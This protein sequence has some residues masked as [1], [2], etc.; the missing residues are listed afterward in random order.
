MKKTIL[1]LVVNTADCGGGDAT[2]PAGPFRGMGMQRDKKFKIGGTNVLPPEWGGAVPAPLI[3][4]EL[5]EMTDKLSE[6]LNKKV[7]PQGLAY[8]R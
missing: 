4:C 1:Y 3:L 7:V 6:G 5:V 8:R 2:R